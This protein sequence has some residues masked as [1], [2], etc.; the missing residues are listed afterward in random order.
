MN[1]LSL[2]QALFLIAYMQ[3]ISL[4]GT[5][6][7]ESYDAIDKIRQSPTYITGDA[8]SRE[9]IERQIDEI[10]SKG[11]YIFSNDTLRYTDLQNNKLVYRKAIWKIEGDILKIIEIDRPYEREA[12][13]HNLNADTLI[14]SPI[15]DGIVG[16]SKIVFS[17]SN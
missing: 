9:M 1:F 8:Y 14:I 7:I 16:D 3:N 4:I 15:I 5:W 6:K 12:Y 13:V 2:L 11:E 17:K 10:L